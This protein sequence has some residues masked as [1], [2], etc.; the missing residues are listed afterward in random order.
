MG[1]LWSITDKDV[2]LMTIEIVNKMK[3]IGGRESLDELVKTCKD[4]QK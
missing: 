4:A 2:D 3:T 1:Y